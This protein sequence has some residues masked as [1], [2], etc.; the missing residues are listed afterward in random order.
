MYEN[1]AKVAKVIMTAVVDG[2][3]GLWGLE[4]G[5]SVYTLLMSVLDWRY[6]GRLMA[7]LYSGVW[8]VS[9]AFFRR[10]VR[11][12]IL[13]GIDYRAASSKA[14]HLTRPCVE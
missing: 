6:E 5:A 7:M 4:C 1:P 13:W 14:G 11:A 12:T 2:D 10:L 9:V 8:T 3:V